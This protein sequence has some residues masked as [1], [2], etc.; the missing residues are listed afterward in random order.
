MGFG[1]VK[2]KSYGYGIMSV[3]QADA[4]SE[5]SFYFI[6]LPIWWC[7]NHGTFSNVGI[8][9]TAGL[10]INSRTENIVSVFL[11]TVLPLASAVVSLAVENTKEELKNYLI[12]LCH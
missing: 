8:M 1:T 9:A 6:M 2:F 7:I 5:S 12:Y 3:P 11:P 10:C 4:F